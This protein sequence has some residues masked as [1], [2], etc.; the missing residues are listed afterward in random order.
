MLADLFE[1]PRPAGNNAEMH[2]QTGKMIAEDDMDTAMSWLRGATTERA[3]KL[4]EQR[5]KASSE[6][7]GHCR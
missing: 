7:K 4:F 1:H 6:R 5:Q 2:P 3:E